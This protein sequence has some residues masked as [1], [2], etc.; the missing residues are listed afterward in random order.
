MN[1][2]GGSPSLIPAAEAV[3]RR[4]MESLL[5]GEGAFERAI[6]LYGGPEGDRD[7]ANA[8]AGLLQREVGWEV[9][10]RNIAL[11]NGSQSAFLPLFNLLAGPMGD[12]RP[13]RRI[14]LP[15]LAGVH[16][17]RGPRFHA[18][19]V[20]R[21][22][23]HH[24]RTGR[25]AVQVRGGLRGIGG[26]RGHRRDLRVAPHQSD[27]QRDNRRGGRA[28]RCRRPRPRRAAHP[29]HRVRRAVSGH[30][31]RRVDARVGRAHGRLHEPV[32][33]RTPRIPHRHRDRE[34]GDRR[35]AGRRH[36]DSTACRRGGSA[37]RS[38]PSSS[39]AASCCRSRAT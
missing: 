32:E 5:R 23:F 37:R 4:H 30:R 11:T 18:R 33:A 22:T 17:L 31:V 35:G 2:G 38:L 28:A 26:G 21:A 12:G 39:R 13:A 9:T 3:F 16:R 8:L 29:G 36:R 19:P 25:Q 6:G 20:H 10:A 34:R 1:L 7:F 24:P 14:L 27:R 15:A